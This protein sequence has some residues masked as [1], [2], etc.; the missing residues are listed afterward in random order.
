MPAWHVYLRF[1][2]KI[3]GPLAIGVGR[4]FGLGL[5]VPG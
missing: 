4:H 2:E 5:F 3:S 1:T